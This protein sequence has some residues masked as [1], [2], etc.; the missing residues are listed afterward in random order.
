MLVDL[1]RQKLPL[2]TDFDR[3]FHQW[4]PNL[5]LTIKTNCMLMAL[6]R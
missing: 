5:T 1:D 6:G 3:K 4:M 2:I